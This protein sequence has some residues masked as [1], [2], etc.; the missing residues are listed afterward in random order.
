MQKHK[1][2]ALNRTIKNKTAM[3][4]FFCGIVIYFFLCSFQKKC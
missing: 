3:I 2:G 4:I 1:L